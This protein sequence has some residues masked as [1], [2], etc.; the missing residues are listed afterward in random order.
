[1]W[2][3]PLAS[4]PALAC[5]YMQSRREEREQREREEAK[6]LAE[7]EHRRLEHKRK[8]RKSHT[9]HGGG[10]MQRRT[11]ARFH[12]HHQQHQQQAQHNQQRQNISAAENAAAAAA[13]ATSTAHPRGDAMVDSGMSFGVVA[14]GWT[15][16]TVPVTGWDGKPIKG[17]AKQHN[18]FILENAADGTTCSV[19]WSQA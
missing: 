12:H 13:S 3:L 19:R 15:T 11:A 16:R 9:G 10:R 1:M 7:N 5:R 6:R 17:T 8:K 14:T 4:S 18:E 2:C